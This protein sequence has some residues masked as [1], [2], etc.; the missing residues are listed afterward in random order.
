MKRRE[1]ITLI[2]GAAWPLAVQAQQPDRMRRIGVLIGTAES[3]PDGQNRLTALRNGMQELG[4]L[5]GQNV[6]IDVRWGTSDGLTRDYAVEIVR[7]SPDVIVANGTPACFAFKQQTQ[8]IPVVFAQVID[9]VG[10]GLVQNLARPRGNLTGFTN[11]EFS[12]GGKWLQ[13]LKEIAPRLIQVAVLFHP[14]TAPFAGSF[15]DLI[16]EAAHSLSVEMVTSPIHNEVGI[17][18]A[19][20]VCARNPDS[21][22][23]VIPSIFM[24]ARRKLI[25]EL[26][27]QSRVPALYP[28]RYFAA[29]GGLMSYG[30]DDEDLFRRAASYVDRILKGERPGDLPVQQ[31]T[32]FELVINL[33]AAKALGL[34]VP[35]TLLTRADAV[36]E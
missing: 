16:E 2:G 24:S 11:Y 23:M 32:K 27:A 36:I 22:L 34:D 31:P 1:F 28:F 12:I 19:I 20:D 18:D 15:L 21:G 5:D 35:P 10:Q 3:D 25:V 7:F 17:S 4:W 33:K 9:P 14:P 6:R 26:A 30:I 8:T 13:L 29:S